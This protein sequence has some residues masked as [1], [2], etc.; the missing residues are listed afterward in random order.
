MRSLATNGGGGIPVVAS[1]K[2]PKD[3]REAIE[4]G[5]VLAVGSFV[6][7]MSQ[8]DAEVELIAQDR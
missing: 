6:R 3:L 8:D 5:D 1:R 4:V 7:A 2:P